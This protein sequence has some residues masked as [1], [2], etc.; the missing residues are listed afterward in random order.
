M[1]VVTL[2]M[3]V[4]I[5][6]ENP[7]LKEILSYSPIIPLIKIASNPTVDLLEIGKY[8]AIYSWLSLVS[9]LIAL[10]GIAKDENI[11]L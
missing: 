7:I 3:F 4:P 6:L 5:P 9:L 10:K 8:M 2:V 1:M 11:R